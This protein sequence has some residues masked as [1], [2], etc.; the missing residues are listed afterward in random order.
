MA[1]FCRV[2][3]AEEV[4][5]FPVQS[6]PEHEAE[7]PCRLGV[8]SRVSNCRIIR[9][10]CIQRPLE[11]LSLNATARDD[12]RCL[13]LRELFDERLHGAI[14]HCREDDQLVWRYAF[15][16]QRVNGC[17]LAG[18]GRSGNQLHVGG[19]AAECRML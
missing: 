8:A 7:Q 13:C 9:D 6:I 5:P 10:L 18:T 11:R 4:A 16:H 14:L 12:E 2:Y 1:V 17:A 3:L 19:Q 15:G